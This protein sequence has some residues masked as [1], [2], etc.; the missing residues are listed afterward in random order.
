MHKYIDINLVRDFSKNFV[1]EDIILDLKDNYK[2]TNIMDDESI[3]YLS[4]ALFDD[5]QLK[6]ANYKSYIEWGMDARLLMELRKSAILPANLEFESNF[7][8]DLASLN[9]WR[10]VRKY[11]ETYFQR[12]NGEYTETIAWHYYYL[13]MFHLGRNKNKGLFYDYESCFA[14]GDYRKQTYIEDYRTGFY[15]CHVKPEFH[16]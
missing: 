5:Y 7:Y 14:D 1:I 11:R 15:N 9:T 3:V 4:E 12:I 8:T 13:A 16:E 6:R 2:I 10:E